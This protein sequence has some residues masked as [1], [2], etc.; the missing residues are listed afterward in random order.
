M[1]RTATQLFILLLV[2]VAAVEEFGGAAL[3]RPTTLQ[4]L[5]QDEVALSIII[6]QL[7]ILHNMNESSSVCA[8]R[9][10]PR[11]P[12]LRTCYTSRVLL[13][14]CLQRCAVCLGVC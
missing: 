13:N 2:M 11:L 12:V 1:S 4:G 3:A 14:M 6:N 9:E 8:S 5:T 7:G 10:L